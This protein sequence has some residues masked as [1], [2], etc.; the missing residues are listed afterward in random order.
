MFA[1]GHLLAL[2]K[3]IFYY[4][5]FKLVG[6]KFVHTRNE[7]LPGTLKLQPKYNGAFEEI[8]R[9]QPDEA[10]KTLGCHISVDMSQTKQFE[11]I[12]DIIQTWIGKIKSSPL[13]M[14][15]RIYAYKTILEKKLLYILPTCSFTYQQCSE[16]DKLLSGTLLNIH[17]IQRNCN[18]NV[19]YTSKELGGLH[20]YI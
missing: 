17:V 1:S 7:E 15:D 11:V 4:Y 19:L 13:S 14:N 10:H 12:K 9:L 3:C 8:K 16:L 5:T 6:T 20:I 2:F 18:R